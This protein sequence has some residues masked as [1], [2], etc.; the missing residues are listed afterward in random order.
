M[1][2][3]GLFAVAAPGA[4]GD[5]RLLGPVLVIAVVMVIGGLTLGVTAQQ[6][7]MQ[8]D[9]SKTGAPISKLIFGGF[10]EPATTGVWAEMWTPLLQRD[11]TTSHGISQS[12]IALVG[13]RGGL[14]SDSHGDAVGLRTEG[15]VM[16][17]LHDHF[18]GALPVA[19][20]GNA[21][22]KPIKGV[23]GIDTSAKPSGSPTFPL[24]V[25]AA[26]SA[27]RKLLAISVVNPTETEQE[28]ELNLTGVQPAGV[29][30][31]RRITAP[32]GTP[33]APAGRAPQDHLARRRHQCI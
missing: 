32:A 24:D 13:G 22:Q 1:M 17:V 20:N 31:L 6:L 7:T 15:L 5:S 27:D 29:A 25:F 9:A 3:L 16:K 23:A 14:A 4:T 2:T 33:P 8:V 26:L 21:P 11:A 19:G 18:A 12:G 30:K 10:M 28:C